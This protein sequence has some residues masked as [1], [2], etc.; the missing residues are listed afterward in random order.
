MFRNKYISGSLVVLLLGVLTLSDAGQ[1]I[2][3]LEEA[4]AREIEKE[5]EL[6]EGLKFEKDWIK[7]LLNGGGD[8]A[9]FDS[10]IND[11]NGGGLG[12]PNQDANSCRLTK[13]STPLY[14]LY[15][16]LKVPVS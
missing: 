4:E 11:R 6:R 12:N 14:L 8:L 3:E 9:L 10:S 13:S 7:L 5:E 1:L 15:C 2:F 16:C